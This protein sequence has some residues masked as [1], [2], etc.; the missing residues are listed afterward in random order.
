VNEHELR[1][2]VEAVM[3]HMG[4]R[5]LATSARA[6]ITGVNDSGPLQL[7]QLEILPGE[8]PWAQR[9]TEYGFTSA[10]LAGAEA[11]V[12]HVLGRRS[13]PI[14]IAVDDRRFRVKDLAN[15]EVCIYDDLGQQVHLT[16][17]GIVVNGAGNPVTITNTP[18]LH[19]DGAIEATGEITAK[20]GGAAAVTVSGHT[21]A[22]GPAP[23]PGT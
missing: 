16:R 10:P 1:A 22:H 11:A 7:L 8:T 6:L 17:T 2:A 4:Q 12:I 9:V 23:D 18:K 20:A 5:I 3:G 21:H 13:H 14:I 19:V 15:G